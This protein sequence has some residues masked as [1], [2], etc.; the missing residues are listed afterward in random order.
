MF[1]EATSPSIVKNKATQLNE[2]ASTY[3]STLCSTRWGRA[4]R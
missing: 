1:T 2:V 3:K 4:T